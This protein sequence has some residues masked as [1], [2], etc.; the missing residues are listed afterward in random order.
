[1]RRTAVVFVA[2]LASGMSCAPPL[3][4]QLGISRDEYRAAREGCR[5]EAR[6]RRLHAHPDAV[7]AWCQEEIARSFEALEPEQR[8]TGRLGTCLIR[9]IRHIDEFEACME[10]EGWRFRGD[11]SPPLDAP[12]E[13]EE[14]I[15]HCS[16]D[17]GPGAIGS[18]AEAVSACVSEEPADEPTALSGS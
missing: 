7:F 16:G 1:M 2:L 18:Y 10:S 6:Y 14:Q 4:R 13:R 11:W 12:R 15:A 9:G 8:N 17:E 3:Q 5:W